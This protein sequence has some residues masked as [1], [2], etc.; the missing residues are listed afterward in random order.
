MVPEQYLEIGFSVGRLHCTV[1]AGGD[2][3]V[4]RAL[5]SSHHGLGAMEVV[6]DSRR[7]VV[8]DGVR[9]SCQIIVNSASWDCFAV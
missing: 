1:L 2:A 8:T 4:L 7:I 9:P 5:M 3:V 6:L